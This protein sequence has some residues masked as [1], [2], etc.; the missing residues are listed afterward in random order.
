MRDAVIVS[1]AR[2]AIGRAKKGSLRDTRP[3]EFSAPVLKELMKRTPGLDP[4]DNRYVDN[5]YQPLPASML[6]SVLKK[7]TPGETTEP[8]APEFAY[9]AVA[10]RIPVRMRLRVDQRKLNRLL[11]ECA[12]SELTIEI[13]QIR[14]N[15]DMQ[16]STRSPT[17][18]QRRWRLEMQEMRMDR[19]DSSEELFQ[20]D[21]DIE[22]YGIVYVY[23]PV[24]K[25]VL[26]IDQEG[27]SDEGVPM[28]AN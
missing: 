25:E 11:A 18:Q 27:E 13:R 15:P 26:G 4:A 2:T 5:H 7:P 16:R 19:G 9:L 8:I 21:V 20:Y 1:V 24:N 3:E 23:N 14:I 28:A 6:R 12:N 10:K 22:L 17:R